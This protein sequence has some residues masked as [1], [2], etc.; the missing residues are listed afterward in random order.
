MTFQNHINLYPAPGVPGDRAS[1]N[2]TAT[3]AAGPGG[4]VAGA[5]GCYA[6][7]FAWNTYA[8]AGGPG[9]ANSYCL[10]ALKPDGFVQNERQALLPLITDEYSFLIPAGMGVTE[11]ER[12]DFWAVSTYGDAAIGDKVFANL[13]SGQCMAGTASDFPTDVAGSSS[14]LTATLVSG[15]YT[16]TI[17]ATTSGLPEVGHAVSGKHIPAGTFIE[18]IG[19][20]NGSTGTVFLT[21]PADATAAVAEAVTTIAPEGIGGAT[22]TASGNDGSTTLN[23]VS[24][25]TGAI[26]KG[27]RIKQT[28]YLPSGPAYVASIGTYNGVS[29]TVVLS[30]ALTG[31]PSSAAF[32]LSTWIET[33]WYVKSPGN[34]G[35]VIKIG[36]KP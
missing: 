17:T 36:V 24:T 21:N 22:I 16:M 15:S 26:V 14:V 33:D 32:S 10:T 27:S 28:T 7:R 4:L 6:G 12:G 11:F 19:G 35:D 20:Y 1:M 2:P 34:A 23:V 31:T 5:L 25:V 13:I 18:S 3:V 8:T 29:G 30:Q 9:L